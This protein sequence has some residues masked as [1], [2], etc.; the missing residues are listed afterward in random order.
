MN[1]EQYSIEELIELRNTINGIIDTYEDGYTYICNIRSYGKN[2]IEN[3]IKNIHTLQELCHQYYGYDGIVDVYSTNPNLKELDNYGK[4]MYI[5]SVEE[6]DR[7]KGY[8]SLKNIIEQLE[9]E[10]KEWNERHTL[11]FRD[12]PVFGPLYSEEELE[13]FKKELSEYDMNFIAPVEYHPID[14]DS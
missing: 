5:V 8:D 3:G 12:R 2:W 9:M 6:Y 10:I 4:T 14:T 11:P 13:G 7:W 1:I